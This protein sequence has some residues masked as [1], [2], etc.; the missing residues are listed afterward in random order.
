[1][2]TTAEAKARLDI[3]ITTLA[4]HACKEGLTAEEVVEAWGPFDEVIYAIWDWMVI[5]GCAPDLGASL[6]LLVQGITPGKTPTSDS[7]VTK[8]TDDEETAQLLS[9][10]GAI[11]HDCVID[12]LVRHVQVEREQQAVNAV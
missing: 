3:Y 11:R 1:M 12:F 10:L 4:T 2:T 8:T 9:L 7:V 5:T 6:K